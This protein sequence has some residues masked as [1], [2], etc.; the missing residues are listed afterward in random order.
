MFY[1]GKVDR[2]KRRR[3]KKHSEPFF[4]KGPIFNLLKY[5]YLYLFSNNEIE[6]GYINDEL[7]AYTWENKYQF[8]TILRI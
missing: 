8:D 5:V 2:R 6:I 4:E 3:R 1:P 7:Q